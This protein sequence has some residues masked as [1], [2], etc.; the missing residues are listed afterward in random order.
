ME[1]LDDQ[2]ET[3]SVVSFRRERPRHRES[4][5][6]HGEKQ[7]I[8]LLL[9]LRYQDL[10]NVPADESFMMQSEAGEQGGM[11]EAGGSRLSIF[12]FRAAHERPEP[13][14]APPGRIRELQHDDEQRAGD[15]QLL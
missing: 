2:T 9:L 10:A 13:A 7:H 6:Q 12:P 15:H 4:A 1:T 14:G 8:L 5:E 3:E 11:W